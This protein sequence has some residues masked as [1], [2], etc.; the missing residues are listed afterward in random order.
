MKRT[1]VDL[2]QL[3]AVLKRLPD[4][5]FYVSQPRVNAI[6][7][8]KNKK[9]KLTTEEAAMVLTLVVADLMNEA[10]DSR[11]IIDGMRQ[12]H[13]SLGLYWWEDA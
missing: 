9:K 6:L 3:C 7:S 13:R 11:R 8:K 2:D 4:S 5:L 12:A 1:R 10:R